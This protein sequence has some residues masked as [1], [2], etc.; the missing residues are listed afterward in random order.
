MSTQMPNQQSQSVGTL[1]VN[2][3]TT[4]LNRNYLDSNI[5][6]MDS[7]TKKILTKVV[8]DVLLLGCGECMRNL[9]FFET[10]NFEVNFQF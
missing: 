7:D 1:T 9:L 10:D 4:P 8:T 2:T 5:L 3:E 6:M